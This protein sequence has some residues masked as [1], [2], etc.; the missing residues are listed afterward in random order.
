MKKK[1]KKYSDDIGMK[2]REYNGLKKEVEDLS[3]EL[4]SKDKLLKF[5]KKII[6]QCS[7]EFQTMEIGYLRELKEK[8]KLFDSLKK[9]LE[10]RFQDLE[11]KERLFEK[12]V[13]D[14]EIREKEFDSIRK[15]VEGQGKNLELQV[16]IEEQENLTSEGRNLQLLL[17]QHLQ[18]HDLI[19]GKIFNTVNRARDPASLVLDAMSGFYPPHSSERDV[20]FQVG[21]IRRSWILLLEQLL[22][23]A[24]EIN[25]Q[26]RDEALKVAGEWNKKM[27]VGVENSLEV[28]GF[29]HLLAAYRLASAFDS[30]ELES[31]LLF[32][33]QHRQTP[34]L[35]QS[36]GFADKVTG[37]QRSTATG[38]RSSMP[39][40]VGISA[41]TYQPVPSPRNQPRYSG[42]NQSTSTSSRRVQPKLQNHDSTFR[43][44]TPQTPASVARSGGQTQFGPLAKR[45]Q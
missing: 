29:L 33:A 12:R 35:R 19:F 40:L 10:D 43:A 37:P 27:R 36:L 8:E 16:K 42:A 41:H 34:K 17:N 39:M 3:Q 13:K 22:T 28:L 25:A 31:L 2:E 24:P 11:V 38:G 32:V 9:G 18:K 4:A 6:E 45:N 30:N 7:R 14:F 5:F 23:V 44:C 1:Q 21:I 26:V 15:T 20:E